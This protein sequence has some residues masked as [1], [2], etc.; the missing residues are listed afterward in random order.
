MLQ[1]LIGQ[2]LYSIATD[3]TKLQSPC[4][5]PGQPGGQR[6]TAQLF[7]EPRFATPDVLLAPANG[8]SSAGPSGQPAGFSPGQ[9]RQAYG[10]TPITF[11]GT[12]QGDGSGQTIALVDAYNQPN[13]SSDLRAFDS[14]YGLPAPASFTVVNQTGGS[15]LPAVDAGWGMEESLDVEWAHAL[16]PGANILLVEA[17]TNSI[18]DLMAA[19][20]YA[21]NVSN[22]SVVSMSW[23]SNGGEFSTKTSYDS[24]LTTPS[25]HNGVTFVASTGDTGSSGAPVYPSVAPTVL[26][27]GGTQL[28]DDS[29]GNYQSETAWSGSGG[30][31]STYEAQP[32]YQKEVVTQTS[33]QRAV[34]D[35]SYNAST[36][37]SYAVYDS[38]GYGGWITVYGTSAGAPQWAALVAIADQGRVLNGNGTLDGATP[39]LPALYQM[40][41]SNFHDITS[42]SNGAYSAGPGYD[43]VTGV[44]TPRANLVVNSLV[45][46][47]SAFWQPVN[48]SSYYNRLGI[49]S[50]AFSGGG[51]DGS[52]DALN[53]AANISW[54]GSLIP[55]GPPN[56]NDVVSAQ[57]QTIAL[58]A[59]AYSSLTV[60]AEAVQGDQLNQPFTVTYSNGAQQTFQQSLSNW[61][62][63]PHYAYEQRAVQMNYYMTAAGTR[64]AGPDYRSAFVLPRNSQLPVKSITLPQDSNVEVLGMLLQ[65]TT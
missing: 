23:G 14:M 60:L 8:R 40:P 41:S 3:N 4:I 43:L 25:G 62:S 15:V 59:D 64:S 58:P 63:L 12:I 1:Q 30:G 45:S 38:S 47:D 33:T 9:I 48:L 34:P 27:V 28:A 46:Y 36:S 35:V 6:P 20:N 13:I 31:M 61:L 50:K 57:G 2:N 29:T 18:P 54:Q 21:R 65:G 26:A 37:S 19:V 32:S 10:F 24:N 55:L 39:T 22:V 11:N 16:A 53:V 5:N 52:G 17:N 56:T 42:G 51:L 49:A 44:G 7:S